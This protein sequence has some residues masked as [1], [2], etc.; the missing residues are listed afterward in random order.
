MKRYELERIKRPC[1]RVLGP[2]TVGGCPGRY[3]A[4][5]FDLD[6]GEPHEALPVVKCQHWHKSK[7]AAQRCGEKLEAAAVSYRHAFVNRWRRAAR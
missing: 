5:I 2:W 7:E 1:L 4:A 3:K 6:N